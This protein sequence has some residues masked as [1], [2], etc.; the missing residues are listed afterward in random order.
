MNLKIC[1][2]PAI[3]HWIQIRVLH[4]LFLPCTKSPLQN[5]TV[6]IQKKFLKNNTIP[7]AP[8][9][10]RP[11]TRI[12][13]SISQSEFVILWFDHTRPFWLRSD[14]VIL[15][16]SFDGI[17]PLILRYYQIAS[18]FREIYHS[19]I[20]LTSTVFPKRNCSIFKN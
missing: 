20:S 13:N 1:L 10:P 16:W 4:Y 2:N 5:R 17:V 11:V 8:I 14:G 9:L 18:L 12:N 15:I 6:K 3:Y 7:S 19:V